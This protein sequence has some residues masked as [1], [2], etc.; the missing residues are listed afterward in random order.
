M[1]LKIAISL[2]LILELC[3]LSTSFIP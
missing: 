3:Q 1:A 2:V